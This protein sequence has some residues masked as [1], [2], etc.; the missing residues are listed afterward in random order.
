[1]RFK[2]ATTDDGNNIKWDSSVNSSPQSLVQP[3][4]LGGGSSEL[5]VI[6]TL[7]YIETAP[8]GSSFFA[9][10]TPVLNSIG[11]QYSVS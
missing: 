2:V 3:I 9:G 4:D 10:T 8:V 7:N 1:M 11:I 6:T 5:Y